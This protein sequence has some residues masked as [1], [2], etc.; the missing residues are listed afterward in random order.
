MKRMDPEKLPNNFDIITYWASWAIS[1]SVTISNGFLQL[2]SIDK[3]YFTY[4]TS[5]KELVVFLLDF[6]KLKSILPK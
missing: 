6:V 5:S 4:Y 2:F 1:L 3:Q